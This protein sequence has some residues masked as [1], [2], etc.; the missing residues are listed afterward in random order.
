VAKKKPPTKAEKLHMAA[1]ADLGCIV[2]RNLGFGG[3][4]A[5]IH[6]VR[7]LAGAGQKAGH[8]ETIGLCRT[9]HLQHGYGISFHDGKVEWERNYG[10]EEMLLNQ[11]RKLLGV[12]CD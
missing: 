10:T 11:T 9:H 7:Y 8:F 4:P 6:H 5:E 1:V 3:T 12:D 2:C